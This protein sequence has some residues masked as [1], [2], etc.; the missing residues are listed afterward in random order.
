MTCE[1]REELIA[2]LISTQPNNEHIEKFKEAF[3]IPISFP[4]NDTAKIVKIIVG[5][6]RAEIKASLLLPIPPKLL[7]LSRPSNI[8]K[9]VERVISPVIVKASIKEI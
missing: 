1:L 4:I 3:E 6:T 8:R 5:S 9:N 2:K 7:A